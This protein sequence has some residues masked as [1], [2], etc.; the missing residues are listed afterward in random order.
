MRQ[1]GYPLKII[2][3]PLKNLRAAK[4]NFF[5]SIS[6]P[7]SKKPQPIIQQVSECNKKKCREEKDKLTYE[8]H[9]C[10]RDKTEKEIA[11]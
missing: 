1:K 4:V 2:S 10:D 5:F 6:I 11:K 9:D 3:R 8:E 7:T